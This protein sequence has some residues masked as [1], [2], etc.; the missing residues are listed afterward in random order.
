MHN[1]IITTNLGIY[2][3]NIEDTLSVLGENRVLQRIWEH[4]HTLWKPDTTEITNRLGWLRI[5]EK[6]KGKIPQILALVNDVCSE[7]Y[8]QVMLLGM[9]GSSLAP[10]LF[11]KTFRVKEGY[12]D[13]AVLDSTDPE[14]VLSHDHQLDYTK[15]LFIVS[16]K[17]GGTVETLS[18][19]KYFYT[20]TV[21]HLGK[22]QAGKHFIAIT[23][24]S[25]EP[26][27]VP[28]SKLEKIARDHNFRK[29]FINDPNIGGR[30]SALSFFG[31][32]PA[33]LVGVDINRFLD[34]AIEMADYDDLGAQVGAIMGTLAEMELIKK[35]KVT[36][37]FSKEIASFG[38]W[39]EQ[40]IAE[41][42]GK[43]GVGILPVV[44]EPLGTPEVYGED[45]LFVHIKLEE[46]TSD[47]PKLQNLEDA[48]NPIVRIHLDDLYDLGGQFFLWELAT[49]V[50]GHILK[51]NPFEQPNVESAKV[52][53][54]KMVAEFKE[55]G[56]LPTMESVPL[57]RQSLD[58]FLDQVNPEDYIAL[59]AYVP[60]TSNN[61]AALQALR[62]EL[63]DHYKVATTL[64][65]GPR[66]LHSTGQLQKGDAGNGLFIQFTNKI[67]KDVDIPDEAGS[68]S[69][70]ISFGTLKNAQAL[71]DARALLDAGRRLIRFR[72]GDDPVQEISNI[73]RE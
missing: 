64:G 73:L 15:T 56:A 62:L 72:L 29:I 53:A 35:D 41:S 47:D 61:E 23:D 12:L 67:T 8:T 5:A 46:N 4:D 49:A 66:F 28:Y 65:F 44:R 31:M 42:T 32:V 50:A 25:L 6:M 17:S 58:Q 20:R 24:P 63:R 13:L 39:V 18:F 37:I 38:D 55:K 71:G 2:Q 36:F 7:G 48:G 45:R 52:Q 21:E 30:F 11:R 70:S 51:I 60:P 43:E 10:E 14:A 33:A 57:T 22:D 16:T 59:Q 68:K 19:F 26:E 9:G 1:N 54:R 34:N 3:T 40:L 27:K 69:A